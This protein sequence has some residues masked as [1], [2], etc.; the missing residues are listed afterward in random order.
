MKEIKISAFSSELLT[1]A[2]TSFQESYES[3]QIE[4]ACKLA[5][6]FKIKNT[7][8]VK[9]FFILWNKH[10]EAGR[11]EIA[12]DLKKKYKIPRNKL[13]PVVKEV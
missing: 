11:Y 5:H 9:A 2:T 7:R 8:A 6:H 3:G 13:E 1:E 12:R 10:I 4:L